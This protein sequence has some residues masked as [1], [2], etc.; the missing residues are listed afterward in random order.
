MRNASRAAVFLGI[1]WEAAK[2][3]VCFSLVALAVALFVWAAFSS[4]HS[5]EWYDP[6][7]SEARREALHQWFADPVVQACCKESDAFE[8]DDFERGEPEFRPDDEGISVL[9]W[10]GYIAVVTDGE[11]NEWRPGLKT[12]TRIRVP[13]SQIKLAPPP[14]D[15]HGVI[16]I[17]RGWDEAHPEDI[18]VYC[19][20]PPAGG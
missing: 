10:S 3:F 18:Y 8:A 5:E 9:A 16:F 1:A 15:G 12:G 4:A 20:F 17:R 2:I 13:D 6:R 7:K 14:P 19:Y 11:S